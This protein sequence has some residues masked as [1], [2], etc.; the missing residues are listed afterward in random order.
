M[1]A[2]DHFPPDYRRARANFLSACKAA[3]LGITSR[4]H[5][6]A[7]ARDGKALFLDTAT[8]GPRDA[9]NALLLISA[10]HGVEGYFG[11]GVQTGLLREGLAAPKGARIVFLHALNP[12]GFAFLEVDF[13]AP[14]PEKGPVKLYALL[15][16]PV[17][18]ASPKFRAL[19]TFH[20]HIF[21]ALRA[22]QWEKTRELIDQGRKLSGASQKL[23]DLHLARIEYFED[24]PPGANWDGAFRQ[25]LK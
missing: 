8:V 21:Q 17:V 4:V 18:R 6:T 20:D 1:T 3:D 24:N 2:R 13:I 7:R 23:Y 22:Q 25:I 10:T 9:A 19:S 14:L 15:G 5:P 12:Y 16:N 11:S